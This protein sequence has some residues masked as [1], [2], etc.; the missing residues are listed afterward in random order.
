MEEGLVVLKTTNV[1]DYKM[2]SRNLLVHLNC[3]FRVPTYPTPT[4][5]C[6]QHVLRWLKAHDLMLCVILH[7]EGSMNLKTVP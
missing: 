5:P 1:A 4:F 3:C 2:S 6:W 7:L